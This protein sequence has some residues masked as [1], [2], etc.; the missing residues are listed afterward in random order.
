[1]ERRTRGPARVLLGYFLWAAICWLLLGLGFAAARSLADEPGPEFVVPTDK[2][3]EP[4]GPPPSL[5]PVVPTF[6]PYEGE[7]ESAGELQH[8]RVESVEGCKAL[9]DRLDESVEREW[10]IVSQLLGEQR[11]LHEVN[12]WLQQAAERDEVRNEDLHVIAHALTDPE[13]SPLRT[14][15][16]GVDAEHPLP[17]AGLEGES[18]EGAAELVASID[19]AGEATKLALWFIAGLVVAS[20][21]G[22]GFYRVVDRN[23]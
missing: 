19:A 2:A 7:D 9:A 5:C 17:V 6:G 18:V 23:T 14:S 4:I 3:T 16:D 1:M 13:A 21:V 12:E 10:W 8:L 20:V 11:D 15:L 22:Y